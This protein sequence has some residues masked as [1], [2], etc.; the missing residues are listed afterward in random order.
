MWRSLL[1][2]FKPARAIPCIARHSLGITFVTF[3]SDAAALE[4]Q[5]KAAAAACHVTLPV[6]RR[7]GQRAA[8]RTGAGARRSVSAAG[9]A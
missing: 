2:N 8:T 9:P 6:G 4:R 3:F 7:R 1:A 5:A